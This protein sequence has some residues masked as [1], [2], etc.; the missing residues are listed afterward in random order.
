M[1]NIS[2]KIKSLGIIAMLV[3]G[4]F[5]V[6]TIVEIQTARGDVYYVGGNGSN[7]YTSIQ[8]AL[9][10]AGWGDT[11]FV[12]NG[13]YTENIQISDWSVS[14]IGEDKNTTIIDGGN[15]GN[16]VTVYGK[17]VSISGF[18]LTNSSSY[19]GMWVAQQSGCEIFKNMITD[20]KI[21]ISATYDTEYGKIH[22]N[23]IQNCNDGIN[24]QSRG[25]N[26]VSNNM[27]DC[28]RWSIHLANSDDSNVVNC[29]IDSSKRGIYLQDSQNVSIYDTY[30]TT[31]LYTQGQIQASSS[32]FVAYNSTISGKS[33]HIHMRNSHGNLINCSFD[34][35]KIDT[36]DSSSIRVSWYLNL[37]VEDTG[38]SPVG[39]CWL[40]LKDVNDDTISVKKTAPTGYDRWNVVT[41]YVQ[42]DV[43]KTLYNYTPH[44]I[45]IFKGNSFGNTNVNLSQNRDIIIVLNRSRPNIDNITIEE[46]PGNG[47]IDNNF[48]LIYEN[49]SVCSS[50]YNDTLGYL[51]PVESDW[52]SNNTSVAYV[53]PGPTSDNILE[54]KAE[55]FCQLNITN[56]TLSYT[57]NI[58]TFGPVKNLDNGSCYKHIQ[59]AVDEATPGDTIFASSN[60]TY[61][62]NVNIDKTLILLGE[63][64]NSTV[65]DGNVMGDVIHISA[66]HVN[67]SGF[68]INNSG[69]NYGD[70]GIDIHANQINISENVI[71][72][73]EKGIIGDSDYNYNYI[74]NN[75]IDSN[76]NGIFVKSCIGWKIKGNDI[77]NNDVGISAKYGSHN[78]VIEGND[79]TSS[80]SFGVD[81]DSSDN[82][83][84][85]NNNISSI[86]KRA[87]IFSHS[88]GHVV[89][90]CTIIDNAYD[91]IHTYKAEFIAY[92]TTINSNNNHVD[93]GTGSSAELIN[94]S[95]DKN[96][97]SVG[98]YSS[99]LV[100]WYLHV[101]V[102]DNLGDGVDGT[103]VNIKNANGDIVD[104]KTTDTNGWSRWNL[105]HEY[106]QNHTTKTYY[107]PHNVSA[108]NRSHAGYAD[109]NVENSESISI[110][111]D[112][113]KPS[114]DHIMI[115]ND[116]DEGSIDGDTFAYD[117]NY[118]LHAS[119]YNTT[120]GYVHP[121]DASWSSDNTS[122]STVDPGPSSKVNMQT[123]M[124]GNC[125]IQIS[126]GTLSKTVNINVFAPVENV[127]QNR[128]YNYIQ[129][130]VDEA[131]TGDSIK[132]YSWTFNETV[133][134]NKTISLIGYGADNTTIDAENADYA[135]KVTADWVN[136]TGF[137]VKNAVVG[138][139]LENHVD[140]CSIYGNIITENEDGIYGR[141][142]KNIN[143][144]NN[145]VISNSDKGIELS[146]GESWKLYDNDIFSNTMGVYA[147]GS[148]DC[149]IERNNFSLSTYGLFVRY[150][151]RWIL[152]DN[153]FSKSIDYW[154]L[155][156]VDSNDWK[157]EN[158]SIHDN[159][160]GILN[161]DSDNWHLI[162]NSITMN[163]HQNIRGD[164]CQDW[165]LYNNEISKSDISQGIDFVNSDNWILVSN[166]ISSNFDQGIKLMSSNNWLIQENNINDNVMSG[167]YLQRGMNY[168]IKNNNIS[169]NHVGIYASS[170]C[171]YWMVEGNHISHNGESGMVLEEG[172]GFIQVSNN[173]VTNNGAG[174]LR[175]LK[176]CT[177][178]VVINNTITKNKDGVELQD[179]HLVQIRRCTISNN[180]NYGIKD[181][182]GTDN[183][184]KNSD[185]SNNLNH[186]IFL[187][188]CSSD[189]ICL[190]H[191]SYN[192]GSDNTYNNSRVQ[193][194][195]N[196][197]G[198]YWENTY[199]GNYWL[200]WAENNVTNDLNADGIVDWPYKLEGENKDLYPIKQT[201]EILATVPM[202]EADNVPTGGEI[203]VVFNRSMDIS[204][205]PELKQMSGQDPGGWTFLGWDES[206]TADDTAVWGHISWQAGEQVEMKVSNYTFADGEIGDEYL[207]NFTVNSVDQTSPSVTYNAPTG[208][209][210]NL[211]SKIIIF[212]DESMDKSSVEDSLSIS[213]QEGTLGKNDGIFS[214]DPMLKEMTFAL[215]SNFS[216]RTEYTV[217]IGGVDT[218]GNLISEDSF[219]WQFNTINSASPESEADP[220]DELVS[221]INTEEFDI[222]YTSN[223]DIGLQNITLYYRH[224]EGPWKP[225]PVKNITGTRSEGSITFDTTE[226][227]GDGRY[228]FYTLAGDNN[229]N[230][231]EKAAV[232]ETTT[233]VDTL[234][235]EIVEVQPKDGET[236]VGLDED[237]TIEFSESMDTTSVEESISIQ[238]SIST[239]FS[240]DDDSTS[241]TIMID[242]LQYEQQYNLTIGTD[243]EDLHGNT[244]ETP[245]YFSFTTL[246]M[247]DSPPIININSPK[248]DDVYIVGDVIDINWT[249]ED[250]NPL[251]T[252]SISIDLSLDNGENWKNIV[253]N[254]SDLGSYNWTSDEPSESAV[255]RVICQD[256]SGQIAH[257]ETGVFT[258]EDDTDTNEEDT[259]EEIIENDED[260]EF[261]P[262]LIFVLIVV[263][264]III[265]TASILK[266]RVSSD[267]QEMA[268]DEFKISE[269]IEKE[270]DFSEEEMIDE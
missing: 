114:I 171:T 143:I 175:I 61:Y 10:D 149:R 188:N 177:D 85:V 167:I 208:K 147:Q 25:W 160:V 17:D 70:A 24:V 11:I 18:T 4:F 76:Q 194:Y 30:I 136:I 215:N 66:D 181:V 63:D 270:K 19:Y 16:I 251:P 74:Y 54:T 15:S 266:K 248:E 203:K 189:T 34:R 107:T 170:N 144:H 47:G 119:G 82:W 176:N 213:N 39:S 199:L 60:W 111:L 250:D 101:K 14:V 258:I 230:I 38:G 46:S 205:I 93:L 244:M 141:V 115:E 218:N 226:Y 79:V 220:N 252:D 138:I 56:G 201:G 36:W 263:M 238:P 191:I 121:I 127:D 242:D 169:N 221:T 267:S 156:I 178:I 163:E 204:Y 20:C 108:F 102:E 183:L 94:C 193:A 235:P 87:L 264:T 72:N 180:L 71:T 62:E 96:K 49:Y 157:L 219:S 195:D 27:S 269:E 232:V 33:P 229:G 13:T 225:G 22:N 211:S 131:D 212:F 254:I 246:N 172:C 29:K 146:G 152:N 68:T 159:G 77:L 6:F 106:L 240:W 262:I 222:G 44:V 86:E 237:I 200:D 7:N 64:N 84:L 28:D 182:D 140:N 53:E 5:T 35:S 89:N 67:V 173:N 1:K 209:D 40:T 105:V 233:L 223:D 202:D 224:D 198:N 247:P 133:T 110:T 126:N 166:N 257:D 186:G 231:E 48:Y 57:A 210:V 3:L 58:E 103:F 112:K 122:V 52:E 9:D 12:H 83:V 168:T 249:I 65:L 196:S 268:G 256:N 118:T 139:V 174:G 21:G 197:L 31:D 98:S 99:C 142:N 162:N 137:T 113:T 253:S 217:S 117:S 153:E 55:G 8:A 184:V 120:F 78:W 50:G 129:P 228:D 116:P 161:A 234:S 151:H 90:N 2:I 214:W 95:F 190:N 26:L 154:A 261:L 165:K 255:I 88:K 148:N 265:V 45:Y 132:A 241:L 37:A 216:Y 185:I 100:G 206:N 41:E 75:R 259:N 109:L 91:S 192:H 128:F 239:T 207:W 59:S 260:G 227:G 23:K 123:Y 80:T 236:S 245:Y 73:C 124:M 92:N 179:S 155:D 135:L 51:H 150:S 97:L 42:E 187:W 130:A 69:T 145:S 43:E 243:S 134:I 164:N 104:V 81:T 125:S 32:D 158:N